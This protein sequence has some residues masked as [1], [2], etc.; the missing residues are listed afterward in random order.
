[1]TD[2]TDRTITVNG[3]PRP[4]SSQDVAALLGEQG[5]DS[6]RGGVA[7]AVNGEVVPRAEWSQTHLNPDDRIEI[8]HIVRGG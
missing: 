8:V 6:G 1:M 5:I 2:I 3:E 7:V 4:W